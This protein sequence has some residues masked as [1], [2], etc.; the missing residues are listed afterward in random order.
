MFA[1]QSNFKISEQRLFPKKCILKCH[2]CVCYRPGCSLPEIWDLEDSVNVGKTPVCALL[3]ATP[4]PYFR[5]V[6]QNEHFDV[7]QIVR[8][9]P[10]PR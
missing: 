3:H 5:R 1:D 4:T 6:F 7:L 2:W 9:K 10:S 8:P